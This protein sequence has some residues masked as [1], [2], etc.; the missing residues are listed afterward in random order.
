MGFLVTRSKSGT[1]KVCSIA[2]QT[3]Q[4]AEITCQLVVRL[5]WVHAT[6]AVE[7]WKEEVILLREES[8]RLVASFTE[9]QRLWL[10]KQD[11]IAHL[12]YDDRV[13]RGYKANAQKQ[14]AVQGRLAV[15]AQG[16]FA[17]VNAQPSA[18]V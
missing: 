6:A 3:S 2:L 14:A 4:F 10:E 7:R 16:Q 18:F 11:S 9:E 15:K 17:L 1:K 12:S 13:V 8:R 5:E